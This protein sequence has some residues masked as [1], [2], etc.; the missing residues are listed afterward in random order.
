MSAQ[1]A[2]INRNL[3]WEKQY[4]QFEPQLAEKIEEIKTVL[5]DTVEL[6]SIDE[7]EQ[8]SLE[9]LAIEKRAFTLMRDERFDEARQILYSPEYEAQKK[10]FFAEVPKVVSQLNE[11][12]KNEIDAEY[13]YSNRFIG[14]AIA[15]FGLS[16]FAWIAAIRNISVSHRKLIVSTAEKERT[17]E[18]LR[19]SEQYQNLFRLANDAIL[20]IEP[21]TEIVLDANERACEVYGYSREVFI[22][23]NLQ[24]ISENAEKNHSYLEELQKSGKCQ[25][26]ETVQY[27]ADKTPFNILIISSVFSKNGQINGSIIPVR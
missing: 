14:I 16:L 23:L 11:L 19:K 3:E 8:S 7:L 18:A 2:V 17:Q 10:R 20:V 21:E 25:E 22:G 5:P 24:D 15:V 12:Q 9:L 4:K 27:R 1:T 26:F 6:Q 13:S